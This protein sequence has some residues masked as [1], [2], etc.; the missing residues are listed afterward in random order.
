MISLGREISPTN[1][2]I[3]PMNHRQSSAL[4]MSMRGNHVSLAASR[5]GIGMGKD[6]PDEFAH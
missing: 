4:K 5:F 2:R 1:S 6:F 3:E